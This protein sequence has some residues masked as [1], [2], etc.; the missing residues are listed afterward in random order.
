MHTY[1]P[2]DA[3]EKGMNSAKFLVASQNLYDALSKTVKI[4]LIKLFV[5]FVCI[6]GLW[7]FAGYLKYQRVR[8]RKHM[9]KDLGNFDSVTKYVEF[10]AK[11]QNLST[12]TPFLKKLVSYKMHRAPIFVK[13]PLYQMQK[14]SN[15]LLS[16]HDW[17]QSRLDMYNE[18][19]FKTHNKQVKF[20]SE[21]KL[22]EA[23]NSAYSY[24]M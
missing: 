9:R 19:K 5:L 3:Y 4:Y 11:V 7:I 10:K 13:Y 22:W 15:T 18:P 17:L 24:W 1:N 12:V 6:P 8:F 21:K 14:M 20:T 16:Y 2:Y 23:R